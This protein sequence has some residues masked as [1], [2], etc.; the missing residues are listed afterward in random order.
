MVEKGGRERLDPVGNMDHTSTVVLLFTKDV[1]LAKKMANPKNGEVQIISV[2]VDKPLQK[3]H[4]KYDVT[5][6]TIH[7]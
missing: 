7:Y 2:V 3:T 5:Y 6:R 1:D 4:I